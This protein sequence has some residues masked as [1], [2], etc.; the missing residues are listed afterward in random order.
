MNRLSKDNYKRPDM[1]KTDKL[2]SDNIR[3][4]LEDYNEFK[5]FADV[6][7]NTHI[8]YF[9]LKNGKQVFRTGGFLLNKTGYPDY[10]VLSSGQKDN[11]KS[12]S[13][14]IKDTTF[15]KKMSFN[16]LKKEYDNIIMALENKIKILEDTISKISK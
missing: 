7:L 8:R 1:T 14:Q 5:S 2:T 10:V 13:V 15:F 3:D 6:P 12:W 11:A 4:L 9:S 16:D